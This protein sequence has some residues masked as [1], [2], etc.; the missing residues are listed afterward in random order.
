MVLKLVRDFRD[1]HGEVSLGGFTPTE[2]GNALYYH[3]QALRFW[4][5]FNS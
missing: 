5:G 4:P 2:R 3:K 1:K